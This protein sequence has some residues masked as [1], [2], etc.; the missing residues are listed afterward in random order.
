MSEAQDMVAEVEAR[1]AARKAEQASKRA[2][3]RVLD[4]EALDG[5]EVE[6]GDSNVAHLDVDAGPGLPTLAAVRCPR[7]AE[8]KRYQARLREKHPDPVAAAEEIGAACLVYPPAGEQRS[9]LLAA[10]PGLPVQLG[11]LA[12][13][14]ATGRAADEGKE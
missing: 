11:T 14:L 9:A 1:R 3:Q 6:H 13:E 5:L 4:L 10:R 2:E 12:L 8:V 7:P